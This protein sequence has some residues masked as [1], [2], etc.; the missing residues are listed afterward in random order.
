MIKG[1]GQLKLPRTKILMDSEQKEL[2]FFNEKHESNHVWCEQFLAYNA[3]K[4]VNV[5]S[6]RVSEV[7]RDA[8][9]RMLYKKPLC[10]SLMLLCR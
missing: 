2:L 1:Y 4:I 7:N 5:E 10:T 9:E 6:E 8:D 3:A